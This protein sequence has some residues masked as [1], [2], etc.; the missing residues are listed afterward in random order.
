MQL[1][2]CK[3]MQHLFKSPTNKNYHNFLQNQIQI[4]LNTKFVK[5]QKLKNH[6]NIRSVVVTTRGMQMDQVIPAAT[7][8]LDCL[9]SPNSSI[10]E[11]EN[12]GIW[13][14]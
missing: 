4:H 9:P 13:N 8:L 6:L 7:T 10:E 11:F 1:E 3:S 14:K 12:T 2:F 5:P